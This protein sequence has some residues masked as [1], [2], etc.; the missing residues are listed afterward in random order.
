MNP[1]WLTPSDWPVSA[2]EGCEEQRGL[3]DL[4]DGGELAVDGVLEHDA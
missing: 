4:L 3:G 2:F 1:P